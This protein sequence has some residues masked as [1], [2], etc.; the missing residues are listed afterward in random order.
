MSS[1]TSG[2]YQVVVTA[3]SAYDLSAEEAAFEGLDVNLRAV[4]IEDWN[5]LER[6]L[7]DA[8]AVIDRLITA[9]YTAEIIESASGLKV[10]GRGGIGV[11]NIDCD[12]AAERGVYV[13]N[14]PKYC[15]EEVSDHTLLLVLALQRDLVTYN[16][17]LKEGTWNKRIG[18]V[19]VHRLQ[20][21]TLGLVGFG[22]IAH[23]VALK[24]QGLGMDVIARDPYVD[25]ES[26]A[27]HGV[28]KVSLDELLGTAD[29]VSAHVPLIEETE[30]MF[31]K[32]MFES[33]KRSAYFVNVSRG[34][35]VVEDDLAWAI[36]NDQI[37]G[38][39]LD[40][41]RNEPPDRFDGDNPEFE[42]PL[43][44]YDEVIMTPHVAWYSKEAADEKHRTVAT[45]VR[46]V[47]E[48]RE[49]ENAVNDPNDAIDR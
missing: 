1:N 22:T 41:H 9:P 44:E 29:F 38:A 39:A 34:G 49:P 12:A 13:V 10:I 28:T 30:D 16:E 7:R 48:G 23:H 45:D 19:D 3:G 25:E 20:E 27:E 47:L 26:I 18:N 11:D 2:Q 5:D 37:A 43:L 35:L 32:S 14:V 17:T 40:V 33:M 31:D 24:A 6:E 4:D 42:S 21:R 36:E 46:R 8:D 15:Q